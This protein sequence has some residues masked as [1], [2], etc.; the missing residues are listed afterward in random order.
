MIRHREIPSI[1][2][3]S[4]HSRLERGKGGIKISSPFV[5]YVMRNKNGCCNVTH[6]FGR[7]LVYGRHAQLPNS[8]IRFSRL[9]SK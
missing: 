8:L 5:F 4:S 7:L 1:F 2:F 6:S 3:C 9:R